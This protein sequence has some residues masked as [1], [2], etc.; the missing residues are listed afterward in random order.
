MIAARVSNYY[1]TN[2]IGNVKKPKPTDTVDTV[3]ITYTWKEGKGKTAETHT[4]TATLTWNDSGWQ[5][6]KE[7]VS[8][9]VSA[10]DGKAYIIIKNLTE[11]TKYT[12]TAKFSNENGAKATSTAATSKTISTTKLNWNP[13]MGITSNASA[14]SRS[15]SVSWIAASDSTNT[16]PS[17]TVYTVKIWALNS[18]GQMKV[19]KTFTVKASQY[20]V[21]DGT[22]SWALSASQAKIFANID[23]Y[24]VTVT[25]K[26]DKLHVVGTETAPAASD[27]SSL[28]VVT[29]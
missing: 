29:A 3:T 23:K 11:V 25:P 13:V 14:S 9:T 12:L 5:S 15:A 8:L 7:N 20:T 26:A 24:W 28:F 17:D 22:A 6:D 21:A 27:T 4:E 1:G 19:K 18:K 16:T 10:A 2:S